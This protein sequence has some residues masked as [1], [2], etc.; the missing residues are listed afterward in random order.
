MIPCLKV[1]D[2]F[3]GTSEVLITLLGLCYVEIVMGKLEMKG[4]V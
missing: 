3:M 4:Q 2:N 1:I